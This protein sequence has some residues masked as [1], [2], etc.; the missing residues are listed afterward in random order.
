MKKIILIFLI[1]NNLLFGWD[2]FNNLFLSLTM[3]SSSSPKKSVFIRNNAQQVV[4]DKTKHLMWQD[5]KNV[6]TI[7]KTYEGAI[8]YCKN[9]NLDGYHDWYLPTNSELNTLL[10]DCSTS[11]LNINH[12]FKNV[13]NDDYW[14]SN[15]DKNNKN[16]A[17]CIYF[18]PNM[19]FT[20]LAHK[21]LKNHVRCVRKINSN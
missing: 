10:I 15:I 19:G 12:T 7:T 11:V 6:K 4:I 20:Y 9:L 3:D 14:T 21:F 17:L 1:F 16:Y 2:F 13:A 5:N 8:D 18:K